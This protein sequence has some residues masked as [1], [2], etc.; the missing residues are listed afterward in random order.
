MSNPYPI[1]DWRHDMYRVWDA[2]ALEIWSDPYGRWEQWIDAFMPHSFECREEK[3]RAS[4][5][6]VLPAETV[7]PGEDARDNGKPDATGEEAAVEEKIARVEDMVSALCQ[8]RGTA[9]ARD[10]TMS[11][12]TRPDYDP[13]L[14]ITGALHVAGNALNSQREEIAALRAKLAEA[15][16]INLASREAVALAE[17][18]RHTIRAERDK[19]LAELENLRAHIRATHEQATGEKDD[20]PVADL[21]SHLDYLVTQSRKAEREV[22]KDLAAMTE[23]ADGLQTALNNTIARKNEYWTER[24][25]AIER[26]EKAEA[27]RCE[28]CGAR[29]NIATCPTCLAPTCCPQCCR[30]SE[31]GAE[32]AQWKERCGKAERRAA[33]LKHHEA[34]VNAANSERDAAR[35]EADRLAGLLRDVRSWFTEE[36][37]PGEIAWRT[38]WMRRRD[39]EVIDAALAG[40]KDGVAPAPLRPI[41]GCELSTGEKP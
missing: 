11:I 13:D 18:N 38:G 39:L 35:T 36:G 3:Y 16:K 9:G 34:A 22:R 20:S 8:P 7:C 33:Q 21:V 17:A 15:E 37:C 25:Q 1:G 41:V 4:P 27:N 30:I 10:W 19:A 14:V 26:A 23:R 31:L 5:C 29:L 40:R 32:A 28:H 24:G 2:G 6:F 12:P